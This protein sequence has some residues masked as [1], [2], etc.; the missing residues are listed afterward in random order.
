MRHRSRSQWSPRLA[1]LAT[2]FCA[3]FGVR[4]AHAQAVTQFAPVEEA[5]SPARTQPQSQTKP[6]SQTQPR[7]RQSSLVSSPSAPDTVPR[8]TVSPGSVDAN[9]IERQPVED[10]TSDADPRAEPVAAQS[11]AASSWSSGLESER[12]RP[13]TAGGVR[14]VEYDEGPSDRNSSD[15]HHLAVSFSVARVFASLY[16]VTAELR[17]A[18]RLSIAAL[19]GL[20]EFEANLSQF[21][22]SLPQQAQSSFSEADERV[23]LKGREFGGQARFYVIGGFDHGLFVGGELLRV[24]AETAPGDLVQGSG[25]LTG[26]GAFLGYK[27]T[28]GFGLMFDVKVGIQKLSVVGEGTAT[29]EVTYMGQTQ[30]VS[31]SDSIDEERTLPLLNV[32]LGWAI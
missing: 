32:N 21:R 27:V 15:T 29:G 3:A 25:T 28:A 23:H 11:E 6:Q 31:A 7:S 22:A 24:W 1:W 19:A 16:E 2:A 18:E 26:S 10:G 30:I 13:L 12:R 9:A 20:G 17:L 4:V 8:A 5:A 14:D